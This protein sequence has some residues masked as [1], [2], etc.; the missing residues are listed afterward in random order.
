MRTSHG[1]TLILSLNARHVHHLLALF[2]SAC[3]CTLH[4]LPDMVTW[5]AD[6]NKCFAA[7]HA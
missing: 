7:V 1:L 3:T 5:K 6:R 4:I 2:T